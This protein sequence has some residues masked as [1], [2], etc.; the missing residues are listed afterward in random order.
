MSL[1][2]FFK[3]A[4]PRQ[5]TEST[6]PEIPGSRQGPDI[7]IPPPPPIQP[8]EDEY[9]TNMLNQA[10]ETSTHLIE[11]AEQIK[12]MLQHAK[13]LILSCSESRKRISRIT[14]ISDGSSQVLGKLEANLEVHQ[15]PTSDISD[16]SSELKIL[17]E[18]V[19][20]EAQGATASFEDFFQITFDLDQS[21]TKT[22]D[23]LMTQAKA[24]HNLKKT[25][26]SLPEYQST[27]A[28]KK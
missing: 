3:I 15:V 7:T 20:T 2:S 22:T 25:I 14:A 9:V 4:V 1:L 17:L 24:M 11:L 16:L 28:S 12:Q 18:S 23:I 21:L 6:S 8:H 5:K 27:A 26:Q 19:K 13:S 10:K